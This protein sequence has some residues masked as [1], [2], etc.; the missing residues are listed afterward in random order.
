MSC[1]IKLVTKDTNISTLSMHKFNWDVQINR[2]D[3]QVVQID[4]YVHSIGGRRGINDLWMYPRGAEPTYENL[5]EFSCDGSG[6]CWGIRFEP[7]NYFKCKW[8][9]TEAFTSGGAMITRNGE[10]FY[11]CGAGIDE[12]RYMLMQIDDHPIG[13]HEYKFNEN[14]VGRKV[15]W[16][17]EPAVVS[18]WIGGQDARLVISPD[19]IDAFRVPPEFEAEEGPDYY[20][21]GVVVTT[22]FDSHIWWFR[23]E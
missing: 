15:W 16:R 18:K 10:D 6:V 23:E 9:E 19:G 22:A 20:E 11:F 12:A 5:V 4:G 8:D 1:E 14:V 17:S 2:V 3:Y 7:K 21:D 13:F